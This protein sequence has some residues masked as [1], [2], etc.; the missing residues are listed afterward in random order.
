MTAVEQN[1][2]ILWGDVNLCQRIEFL[3]L[4][5]V[6]FLDHQ[7][8]SSL[9]CTSSCQLQTL[10]LGVHGY[11]TFASASVFTT[12]CIK[13]GP[14]ACCEGKRAEGWALDSRAGQLAFVSCMRRQY[15]LV[16]AALCSK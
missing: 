16:L 3:G 7:L 9:Y 15:Q 6:V 5:F 2:A 8:Q 1:E 10:L 11:L 4:W 12:T 13:L 14:L